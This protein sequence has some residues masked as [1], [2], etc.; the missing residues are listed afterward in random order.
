ML[1]GLNSDLIAR[2]PYQR[3]S[4]RYYIIESLGRAYPDEPL[5]TSEIRRIRDM[6]DHAYGADELAAYLEE[7]AAWAQDEVGVGLELDALPVLYA[8]VSD[9]ESLAASDPADVEETRPP[10]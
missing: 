6:G 3:V 8:R 10:Q 7:L 9:A 5:L 4:I 1:D 2:E